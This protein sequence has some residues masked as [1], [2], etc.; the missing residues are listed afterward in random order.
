MKGKKVTK[1][2]VKRIGK[3]SCLVGKKEN[4]GEKN[5]EK[6]NKMIIWLARK[7]E[8]RQKLREKV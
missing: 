8:E 6:N 3:H 7:L 1:R 5:R 2:K 4:D